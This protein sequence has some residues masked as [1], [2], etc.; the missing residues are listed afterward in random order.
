MIVLYLHVLCK[1]GICF[2]TCF[3]QTKILSRNTKLCTEVTCQCFFKWTNGQYLI[4]GHNIL[5]VM[6]VGLK[7][8]LLW[9][10]VKS[11]KTN[12]CGNPFLWS[13]FLHQKK[14][15]LLPQINISSEKSALGVKEKFGKCT[16][17]PFSLIKTK[18]DDKQRVG[19]PPLS[20]I[21]KSLL[22]CT[23]LYCT[24]VYF[25]VRYTVLT[26]LLYKTD[27]LFNL[28]KTYIY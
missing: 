6:L 17:N 14:L 12:Y 24:V 27:V 10:E 16:G 4:T 8:F 1:N 2:N 11:A 5:V 18:T 3:F 25:T 26:L 23:V 20:I 21:I 19:F 28:D 7:K 13:W 15:F 9:F 22:H